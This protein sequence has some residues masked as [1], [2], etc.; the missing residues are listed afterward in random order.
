LVTHEL[1]SPIDAIQSYLQLIID[2][3]V[4]PEQINDIINKCLTRADEERELIADL[5]ELGRL[6]VISDQQIATPIDMGILLKDVASSLREAMEK[7]NIKY[8]YRVE[9]AIQPVHG[10]PKKCR[11][12]W[13]NLLSNAIKYTPEN[14]SIDVQLRQGVDAVIA[15]IKDTGI[16]IPQGEHDR[17]FTEFFRATNARESGIRGTGLGLLIVKR[18][19]DGL[20]GHISV[21]SEIGTGSTFSFDI[22][23]AT[24]SG[25]ELH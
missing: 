23:A 22:P 13:Q 25:K 17:L 16:G 14:G 3:Y 12:L 5:L 6:D 19:L 20:G 18:I 7:K 21:V 9:H 8:S 10:D 1:Q 4:K 11:S 24:S 15:H 2:G